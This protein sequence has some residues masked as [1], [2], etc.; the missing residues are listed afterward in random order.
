M[1][2]NQKRTHKTKSHKKNNNLEGKQK[3][4]K[5]YNQNLA[6]DAIHIVSYNNKQ[7]QYIYYIYILKQKH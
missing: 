6:N 4:I 2:I 3:V 5:S 1:N 7:S